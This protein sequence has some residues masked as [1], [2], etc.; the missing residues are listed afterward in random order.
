MD[1]QRTHSPGYARLVLAMLLLVYIFNFLDRQI[2]G[3]LA[4]PIKEDLQL[5]DSQ[6]GVLGGLAFAVLYST[7]AIPLALLADRTS[8]T[9]VITISM[10][11]WSAFTALCGVATSFA[12]LLA[13][14]IGVGVGEA[15][16][17]APSYAVI[18]DYFPPHQRARAMAIYA[19][20]IPIGLAA[21]VLFGA[22]I[23]KAVDWRAAF[24]VVGLAGVVVAPIFRLVVREPARAKGP[25]VGVPLSGVFAILARKRSFWLMAFAALCRGVPGRRPGAGVGVAAGAQRAEYSVAGAADNGGAAPGAAA[26]ARYGLGELPADQQFDRARAG[27]LE[28]R[29]DLRRAGAAAWAG[30]IALCDGGDRGDVPRRDGAGVFGGEAAAARLGG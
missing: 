6:L 1:E 9:W 23:A 15:G 11:V 10:V 26:D 29:D 24:I 28:H 13:F 27:V 18:G 25:T 30:S 8:R 16:G 12:Q 5:T 20:G 4:V 19:L 22:W 7:L 14:R 17:V 21:G 3:I 2:L